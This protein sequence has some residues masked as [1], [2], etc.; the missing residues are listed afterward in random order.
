MREVKPDDGSIATSVLVAIEK[1]PKNLK[2]IADSIA[3]ASGGTWKPGAGLVL[4]TVSSLVELGQAE[5][6]NEGERRI[7]AITASGLA[8]LTSARE[9]STQPEAEESS[10]APAGSR[11]Y[12]FGQNWQT[13]DPKFLVSASK[14]GPVLLDIAQTGNRSQQEKAATVL[15]EAR[16]KLHVIMAED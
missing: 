8:A 15:E 12:G 5:S 3:L 2:E 7:Y 16:K 4:N 9:A 1:E 14:L 13:C 6:R 11:S 10:T